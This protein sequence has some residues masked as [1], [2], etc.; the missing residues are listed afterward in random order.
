MLIS[1]K[2]YHIMSDILN[3]SIKI[4][5]HIAKINFDLQTKLKLDFMC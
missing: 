2:H 5:L 4:E 3:F 1:L